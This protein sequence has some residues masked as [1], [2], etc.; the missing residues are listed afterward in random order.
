ML[1][2]TLF[3]TAGRLAERFIRLDPTVRKPA[4]LTIVAMAWEAYL[5][6]AGS[7]DA[8]AG[9]TAAATD[10]LETDDRRADGFLS[11]LG[12]QESPL[13]AAAE[14]VQ[15]ARGSSRWSF[16]AWELAM[17]DDAH[18]MLR[19]SGVD[20]AGQP[21]VHELAAA[22][23]RLRVDKR[24]PAEPPGTDATRGGAWAVN[25]ALYRFPA[26]AIPPG[27]V[28]RALLRND[29]LLDEGV[30]VAAWAESLAD[31]DGRLQELEHRLAMVRRSSAEMLV[32]T[33]TLEVVGALAA[34]D[35]LRRGQ[36]RRGWGVSQA[37][38]T[39]L[40]RALTMSGLAKTNQR[41]RLTWMGA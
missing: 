7:H 15:R 29:T 11:Y 30:L 28:T 3:W 14:T 27:L 19:R 10:I 23:E 32:R 4:D 18:D 35:T 8:P 25:L 39:R 1:R 6:D 12:A 21:C 38:T 26:L 17:I 24:F 9:I 2:D 37:A 16:A 41:G 20:L 31:L 22:I 33:R 36:I 40:I 34:L 13:G 5:R